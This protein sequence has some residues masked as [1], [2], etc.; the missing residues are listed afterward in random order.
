[1]Y[2]DDPNMRG[3]PTPAATPVPTAT[4]MPEKE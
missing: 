4:P 1:M 2:G 3:L